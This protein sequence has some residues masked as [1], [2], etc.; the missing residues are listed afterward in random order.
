MEK[1]FVIQFFMDLF[2]FSSLDD[3][4]LLLVLVFVLFFGFL[5]VMFCGAFTDFMNSFSLVKR[6]KFL[7]SYI[8]KNKDINSSSP[9]D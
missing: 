1:S 6:V 2:D 4:I 7:E 3:L 8:L 9:E 5:L